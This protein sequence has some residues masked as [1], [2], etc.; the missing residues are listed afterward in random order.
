VSSVG[1][2]KLRG[3]LRTAALGLAVLA[4]ATG[5]VGAAADPPADEGEGV[6]IVQLHLPAGEPALG[7]AQAPLTM[8]EFTDYQCPYCRGFQAEVWPK[9]KR[10]YIDTGKL[11][12]IARDLPL[13]FHASA[14]PAAEAAHCAGEQGKF[15]SMHEAL[16]GGAE[17]LAGGGIDKRAAAVGLDPG[18]FH[19]CLKAQRY[20]QTIEAHVREADAAGIRGTPGFVVGRVVHGELQGVRVEGALPYEQFDALLRELLT[21]TRG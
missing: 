7:R 8:V 10:H 2:L 14:G 5:V 20:A 12:F 16:L 13:E 17:D 6:A 21:A 18:R 9:L 11:R 15:W 4:I 3:A 19:E 1:K